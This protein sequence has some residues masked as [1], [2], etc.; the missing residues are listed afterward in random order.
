MFHRDG[1]GTVFVC[2]DTHVRGRARSTQVCFEEEL[3]KSSEDEQR[4]SQS[5]VQQHSPLHILTYFW[6]AFCFAEEKK[7]Q[8]Q[9][10]LRGAQQ[11][12]G[13]PERVN[14]GLGGRRQNKTNTGLNIQGGERQENAK[15]L[16]PAGDTTV[17]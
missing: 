5:S 6:V 8:N 12:F 14:C 3:Q 11:Q 17:A 7:N 16:G 10:T 4:L 15:N 1:A 2:D 13:S 9:Y